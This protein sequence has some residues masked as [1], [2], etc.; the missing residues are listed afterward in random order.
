LSRHP[1]RVGQIVITLMRMLAKVCSCAMVGL[2]GHV[3]DVEVDVSNGLTAF[4]VVGLPDA[5]IKESIERLRAALRHSGLKMPWTRVT[6][7]LAPADIRKAGPAYDLPIALA[8]LAASE[9]IDPAVLADALVIG[10]LALDGA[11]RH[12]RS[13]LPATVFAREHGFKRIIVP[14]VDAREA[15]LIPG[16]DV[17]GATTLRDIVEA[18]IGHALPVEPCSAEL[19]A[20]RRDALDGPLTDFGDIKGQETA[21]R[22]LEIAAAGGHNVLLVGSPGAGKTLMARAMPGILPELT[23]D[24]ALDIT[25]LY[26]VAD[27]LPRDTP[28]IQTRPFRAPHHTISHAGMI[29]GGK[30][31][32]PGEVSLAHRGVLFLDELPEFD[33]RTLEVLRQPVEDKIVQIS[34]ASGS[35]TFPASFMLVAA[36]NPC[37]CGWYGDSTRPCT[38]PPAQIQQYQKKISGPLLDRIDMHLNVTRVPFEKLNDLRPGDASM[39]VRG[40][41]QRARARQ[42]A[43][44]AATAITCNSDMGVAEVRTHCALDEASRAMMKAAM[45]QLQLSARAFHRVLKLARTIADLADSDGL[46]STHVAEALQYR[47]RVAE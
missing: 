47:P 33:A 44:F 15:A 9:Q 26:S 17:V 25:R 39:V 37:K 4:N 42:S 21:K 27:M 19:S 45:A 13:V 34:R 29:G 28:L 1:F 23:L 10:E 31:P 35:L 16:I 7:N 32:R 6:V 18:L 8:L 20:D 14:A 3:I 5:A 11:T 12:V 24:E 38:C 40:R 46:T 2:D 36:M 41:V 30:F 22:A 43:R